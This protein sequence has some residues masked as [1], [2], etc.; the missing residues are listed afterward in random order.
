MVFCY[1]TGFPYLSGF[2]ILVEI[3]F[4]YQTYS[5][6]DFPILIDRC[7]FMKE[8]IAMN[9]GLFYCHIISY[10]PRPVSCFLI[11]ME[12]ARMNKSHH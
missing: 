7:G 8:F 6:L 2:L 4:Y 12:E 5:L 9:Y 10:K 3:I 11:H 1:S